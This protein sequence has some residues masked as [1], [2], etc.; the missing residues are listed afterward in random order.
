[1]TLVVPKSHGGSG[2]PGQSDTEKYGAALAGA[3]PQ[4]AAAQPIARPKPTA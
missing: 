2:G 4:P 3:M 1:M